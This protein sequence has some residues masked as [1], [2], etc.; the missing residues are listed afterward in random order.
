MRRRDRDTPDCGGRVAR[1]TIAA[2]PFVAFTAQLQRFTETPAFETPA[3]TLREALEAAFGL[4]PRLRHYVLDE[5]G[6]LRRHVVVFIDG[7]RVADRVALRD[8]LAPD[9]KVYVLQALTG[10]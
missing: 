6:H 7:R 4:N 3:A 10:G 1:A 8:A 2:M 5:Q 9:A